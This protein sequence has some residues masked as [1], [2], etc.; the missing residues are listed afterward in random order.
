MRSECGRS[1]W[2]YTCNFPLWSVRNMAAEIKLFGSLHTHTEWQTGQGGFHFGFLCVVAYTQYLCAFWTHFNWY[3]VECNLFMQS[4]M[5]CIFFEKAY[6]RSRR[7][8]WSVKWELHEFRFLLQLI[9]E[10]LINLHSFLLVRSAKGRRHPA[11]IDH[12]VPKRY[13][14]LNEADAV[15]LANGW[16]DGWAKISRSVAA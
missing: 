4:E 15:S 8:R 16:M 13:Q 10:C 3:L 7:R 12:R 11:E 2:F 1:F 6:C 14:G 9:C 5:G